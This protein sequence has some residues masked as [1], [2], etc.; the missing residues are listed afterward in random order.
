MDVTEG[1]NEQE[2]EQLNELI[3]QQLI[4]EDANN[5]PN[6]K[7]KKD[8]LNNLNNDKKT[9]GVEIVQ[10]ENEFINNLWAMAEN[11]IEPLIYSHCSV[12]VRMK[13]ADK[14]VTCIID[15]GAQ[16]N[17]ITVDHIQKLGLESYVDTRFKGIVSGIGSG[18]KLGT[19]P[20]IETK[21]TDKNNNDVVLPMNFIV[22]NTSP[23]NPSASY[24]LL[25]L[26]AIM[27]YRMKLDFRES[28]LIVEVDG[29]KE[30]LI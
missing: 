25:G 11:S 29:Q 15:T 18:E 16:T 7:Q 1:L 10:N 23:Q 2:Q 3:I 6:D 22:L 19:I 9:Q 13:L 17:V 20:Y 12:I 5:N 8:N 4:E 30:L 14:E 24:V 28:K 21:F 27:F 26:P